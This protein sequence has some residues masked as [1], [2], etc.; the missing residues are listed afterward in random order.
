[1]ALLCV[2]YTAPVPG[3]WAFRGTRKMAGRL[4]G[5]KE[6]AG[7]GA[8]TDNFYKPVCALRGPDSPGAGG[9]A[10]GRKAFCLL[11]GWFV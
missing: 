1:M 11:I 2:I 6:G 10:G 4:Q 9:E 7:T 5:A 3:A 8:I